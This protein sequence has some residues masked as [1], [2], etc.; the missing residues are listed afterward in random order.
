[1]TT[2]QSFKLYEV[3]DRYY[4]NGSDARIIVTEIEQIIDTKINDKIDVFAT[5]SDIMQLQLEM[6]KR[7]NQSQV[8]IDKR[9][10]QLHDDMEKRF[11]QSQLEIEKRFNSSQVEMEKRFNLLTFWI[12]TTIVAFSGIIIAVLKL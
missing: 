12:V 5:K 6:E 8:D 4:H 9:F 11:N 3:L 7:F 1:M 2:A 10:N